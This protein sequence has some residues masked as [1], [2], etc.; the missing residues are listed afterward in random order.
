[1]RPALVVGPRG[2]RSHLPRHAALTAG[3]Q[4]LYENGFPVPKP[5]DVSRHCVVMELLAAYPLYGPTRVKDRVPTLA[6]RAHSPCA[7]SISAAA[8]YRCQVHDVADPGKLYSAL[9]NLI[10]NLAESGLI[11]SDFNEFN[12]MLTDDDRPILIDFPQMVSTSHPNAEWYFNR[13]VECIRTFFRKRFGYESKLHPRFTTDVT[14]AFS[15]DVLVEASGFA[16][17][18][19]DEFERLYAAAHRDARDHES[20]EEDG[21]AEEEEE[22]EDEDGSAGSSSGSDGDDSD[23]ADADDEAVSLDDEA[24]GQSVPAV[25]AA[26]AAADELVTATRTLILGDRTALRT[27]LQAAMADAVALPRPPADDDAADEPAL[28]HEEEDDEEA[29]EGNDNRTRRPFR[30]ADLPQPSALRAVD[31]GRSARGH[32]GAAKPAL[33]AEEI[34]KRVHRHRVRQER[35]KASQATRSRKNDTKPV[36]QRDRKQRNHIRSELD[37]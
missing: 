37:G 31:E 16:K 34:R 20:E 15:L 13:D 25:S 19:H 8:R 3:A 33:S 9:M 30:E 6:C 29:P 36:S 24:R 23:A 2:A 4:V 28:T 1:M 18:D 12:I 27:G 35:H 32:G 26:D 21:D 7:V 22:D 14:R 5:Y 11:H 17:R 10:V